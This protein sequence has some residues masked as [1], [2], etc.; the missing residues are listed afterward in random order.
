[1]LPPLKEY[2][3][4]MN[5][6]RVLRVVLVVVGLLFVAAIYPVVDGLRHGTGP[7]GDIMMLSIYF[8]LGVFLLLA[9]RSPTAHRSLIVFAGWANLAHASV[10]AVMAARFTTEREHMLVGVIMFG[11]IG[12]V[13]LALAPRTSPASA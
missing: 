12:L 5:R 1:M 13:L 8:A 2:D 3:D 11:T 10:M 9:S 4:R 7:D 6:E